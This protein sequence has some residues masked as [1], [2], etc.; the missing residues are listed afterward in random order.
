MKRMLAALA[1]VMVVV[2]P[3][4]AGDPEVGKAA[5][6]FKLTD[7]DGKTRSLSE[8]KGKHV[9]LEWI[10]HGCPFV[11]KHYGSNNMQTLQKETAAQGVVWLSI[12]SSAKGKEGYM[13]QAEWKKT[14]TDTGSTPTAVL[15]DEKGKA[16][17]AYGA[18]TTPHM[19]VVNPAGVL[20]YKGAIDDRPTY[21]AKDVEGAKNY[22][23]QALAE[24]IAGK[25][26]TEASTKPYGCSVKY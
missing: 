8:F 15:L 14:L 21:E 23:R 6:D 24:S 13:D 5:P 2:S 3:L 20:V 1:A 25:P 11:K 16:G 26:V 12:A 22:V 19:F 10:N 4:F 18:K 7:L 17:K 9:V